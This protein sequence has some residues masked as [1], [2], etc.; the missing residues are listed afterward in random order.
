MP[1]LPMP[2]PLLAASLCV[3]FAA[4]I[5]RGFAG[6]G[7]SALCVAGLSLFMPP[8]Q[9]VPPIFVLEVLASLSL[10]RGALKHADWGWLSW[11]VLG[12]ALCIPLGVALLAYVSET[13]L[14]LLIGALL[15]LAAVL[16][17]GGWQLALEPTPALRLATGLVSGFV[18]GVA[19]IG[20]IAVAVMLSSTALAPAAMRA[21]MILMF[22]FTDL[23]A[24]AWAAVLPGEGGQELLGARSVQMVLWLAPAMLAGIWFGQ[25]AFVGVSPDLFRRRV[26]DLLVLIAALSVLRALWSLWPLVP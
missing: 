23:Y 16:L 26:L 10:L 5:V 20:G 14:R 24:L 1:T 15:L 11:L 2:W 8:A 3:V 6:F 18:N 19:A 21:T 25:R 22:L 13:P 9:V 7:F 4:G 17:R 12:N